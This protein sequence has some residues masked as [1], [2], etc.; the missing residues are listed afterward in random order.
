MPSGNPRTF[1]PIL[2]PDYPRARTSRTRSRKFTTRKKDT[3]RQRQTAETRK[4]GA[5]IRCRLHHIRCERE[6]GQQDGCC[7]ACEHARRS[8]RSRVQG[9][10]CMRDGVTDA[11]LV[12]HPDCPRKTWTRR[13]NGMDMVDI[14][15]WA[16]KTIRTINITQFV[17]R[18]DGV[19]IITYPVE[20]RQFV[21]ELPGDAL[22]RKWKFD[23]VE[24]SYDCE[25]YGI[26]DMEKTGATMKKVVEDSILDSINFYIRGKDTLLRKTYLMAYQYSELPNLRQ[27]E[28]DLLKAVLR[29]WTASRMESR[30]DYISHGDTLGMKPH[31]CQKNCPNTNL[32]LTPPVFSAQMEIIMTS[33]VLRPTKKEVLRL[34]RDL[35]HE[36][37]RQSWFTIYLSLFI[38]LHSCALL[39]AANVQRALK[40]GKVSFRPV[41]DNK[42]MEKLH[43]GAAILLACFHHCNKGSHPFTMDWTSPNDTS[44]GEFTEEQ[45]AFMQDLCVMIDNEDQSR[46]F[47]KIRKE[48]TVDHEY[49]FVAQ[50]YEYA[51]KLP[52]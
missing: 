22:S 36:Q 51:W 16:S 4:S 3:N 27:E 1:G 39:T 52:R 30:S 8:R 43:H 33:M 13:W 19:R 15:R 50:M 11:E 49:Y 21:P 37:Q 40:Q 28:R 17:P 23:G 47:K 25:P 46:T 31:D 29:L 44:L 2:P 12:D 20:V 38:L 32:I 45:R 26:A 14:S 42:V 35:I 18:S 9:L 5:C 7:Q 10:P 24:E 41:L 6:P 34:L 48:R